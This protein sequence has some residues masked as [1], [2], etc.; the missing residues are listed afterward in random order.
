MEEEEEVAA[1]KTKEDGGQEQV[2]TTTDSSSSVSEVEVEPVAA[3]AALTQ[4]PPLLA[5]GGNLL[6]VR[7]RP[8]RDYEKIVEQALANNLCLL[9]LSC[10]YSSSLWALPSPSSRPCAPYWT[11]WPP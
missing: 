8:R 7:K 11:R 10:R 9:I 5:A 2:P 1:A 3:A 6:Q 4:P